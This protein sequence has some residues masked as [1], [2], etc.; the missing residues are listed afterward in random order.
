MMPS[1]APRSSSHL[2]RAVFA[3]ALVL[4]A[5]GGQD[6][7]PPPPESNAN[8]DLADLIRYDTSTADGRDVFASGACE[9][10][11]VQECRVYLPS[12]NGV[13]PCFVGEQICAGD[14]WGQC[15][16]GSLVDANA[17]DAELDPDTLPP[18]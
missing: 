17:D 18:T 8:I 10:G 11:A 1:P 4:V 6:E 5:C 7:R 13:Q 2:P 16:S 12:H 15:E 14:A 3:A 9:D